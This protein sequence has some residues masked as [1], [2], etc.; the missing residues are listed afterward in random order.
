M[1]DALHYVHYIT[2]NIR[3]DHIKAGYTYSATAQSYIA[4]LCITL[5]KKKTR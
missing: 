2:E 1:C 4:A 5:L 3:V